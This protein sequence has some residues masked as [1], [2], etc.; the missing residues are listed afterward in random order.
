MGRTGRRGRHGNNQRKLSTGERGGVVRMRG[1]AHSHP[2]LF[3]A[4]GDVQK[5]EQ[6]QMRLEDAEAR[7]LLK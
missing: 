5:V 7:H 1:P 3:M 2:L 6:D 4:E